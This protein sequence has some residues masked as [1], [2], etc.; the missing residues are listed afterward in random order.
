MDTEKRFLFVKEVGG[1]GRMGWEFG[2]SRCKILYTEWI[3]KK[4]LF[5]ST[6]TVFNI[7]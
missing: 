2:T 5:F 4:I 6:E 1:G 3:A 7:P